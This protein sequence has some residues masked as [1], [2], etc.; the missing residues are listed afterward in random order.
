MKRGCRRGSTARRCLG[1][2]QP[3]SQ[4]FLKFLLNLTLP[5]SLSLSGGSA[6]CVGP[7]QTDRRLSSPLPGACAPTHGEWVGEGREGE[8]KSQPTPKLRNN[9]S[10]TGSPALNVRASPWRPS[11]RDPP[12]GGTL[13][14]GSCRLSLSCCWRPLL[15]QL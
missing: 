12:S 8:K 5:L 14:A 10:A 11:I 9:R 15:F 4:I 3:F 1:V 2:G 6:S 7:D 13:A